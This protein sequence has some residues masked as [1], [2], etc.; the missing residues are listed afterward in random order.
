MGAHLSLRSYLM[1]SDPFADST[2][3]G[4]LSADQ[5]RTIA[6]N[7]VRYR[8]L[9]R[10]A[11]DIGITPSALGKIVLG[12]GMH[13]G[14]ILKVRDWVTTLPADGAPKSYP[15]RETVEAAWGLLLADFSDDVAGPLRQRLTVHI[16]QIY[17]SQGLPLPPWLDEA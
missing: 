9:R 6:Q 3:R 15:D 1:P 5:L 14:T 13:A 2:G 10:V 17:Q 7:E 11:A 12:G 8:G 16:R 4:P